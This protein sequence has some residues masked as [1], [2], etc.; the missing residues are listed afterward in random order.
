MSRWSLQPPELP[1]NPSG[2][3]STQTL[4]FDASPGHAPHNA[5]V[6]AKLRTPRGRPS[7]GLIVV[8]PILGGDYAPSDTFATYLAEHGF[9]TLRFDRKA[10][11]FDPDRGFDSVAA[12]MREGVLDVRRGIDW[13]YATG[14]ARGGVGVLGISM[15]SFAGTILA[16]IDPRIDCAVLA[17]GGGGLPTILESARSEKEI[18]RF[19]RALE[20]RVPSAQERRAQA[21]TH[22]GPIDP[23]RFADRLP[24]AR[25]LMI[26]ARFDAVVPYAS[27]TQLWQAAGRPPRVTLLTGHYSSVLALP[28]LLRLTERHMGRFV[29][30]P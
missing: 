26:H 28:Y 20:K 16:A 22:L 15:G 21:K 1:A 30:A 23:L 19:F 13:A 4:S 9:T 7:R 12:I 27:A 8:L 29:R 24:S 3:F 17:L 18:D 14:R 10:K 25:T 6:R 5:V 11:I 2:A